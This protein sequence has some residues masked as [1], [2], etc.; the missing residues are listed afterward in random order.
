MSRSY[1]CLVLLTRTHEHRAHCLIL[2]ILITCL[3]AHQTQLVMVKRWLCTCFQ[4]FMTVVYE[5]L[6]FGAQLCLF[7]VGR[8]GTGG[9]TTIFTQTT[10][11]FKYL[12]KMMTLT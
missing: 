10:R 12:S 11:S 4:L 6:Y 8:V 7:Q 1:H 5:S 2:L 9:K 3:S